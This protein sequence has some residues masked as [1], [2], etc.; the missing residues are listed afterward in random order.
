MQ[1][2]VAGFPG[3]DHMHV[4]TSISVLFWKGPMRLLK[5]KCVPD[6]DRAVR[7]Y[8]PLEAPTRIAKTPPK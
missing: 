6:W 5:P 4:A 8:S 2:A 7:Q 1:D 3:T